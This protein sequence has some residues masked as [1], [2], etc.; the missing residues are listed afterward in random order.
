MNLD[1][2]NYRHVAVFAATLLLTAC[3]DNRPPEEIVAERAQARWD[4]M[5]AKEFEDGWA[6]Y[7]P[8]YR[9]HTSA[10]DLRYELRGKPVQWNQAEVRAV[11]C[12]E[13]R[14]QVRISLEY[15]LVAGPDPVRGMP[16]RTPLTETWL[17]IDGR[18]WYSS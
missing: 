5:I 12:E 1:S 7:T 8:G 9:Q 14:C 10:Q 15:E 13:D 6:F 2:I 4:A 16:V 11:D 18:W 3:V 17:K